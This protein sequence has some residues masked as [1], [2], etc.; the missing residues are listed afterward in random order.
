MTAIALPI[1]SALGALVKAFPLTQYNK[2]KEIIDRLNSIS[3]ASGVLSS[4]DLTLTGNLSVTGAANYKNSVVDTI[5]AYAT[6]IVL[7][8]AQSANFIIVDTA[9]GLDFTLPA[10]AA[11]QVGTFFEFHVTVSVT[12]NNFRVTAAS[13]D[14]L[15][16]SI[17][18][19][20]DTAAY[21]APQS[22]VLKPNGSSHLVVTMNGTTSG[23]K[24]GTVVRFTAT[25][26]TQWC[27]NGTA[28][29]SGTLAG[30]FS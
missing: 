3:S 21:T 24:S 20:D 29:G 30:I 4:T 1:N 17:L 18:L 2:V 8:A 19:S 7:T 15:F 5:G 6:P 13:G 11:A 12:S 28:N 27:V 25:S 23:G 9:A 22:I 16:G 14:L 26:A 10:I